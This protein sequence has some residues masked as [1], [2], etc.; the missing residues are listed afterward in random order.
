MDLATTPGMPPPDGQESH[1]HEPYNSLQTGTVLAFGITYLIATIFL[2]LRY[3][4]AFKLTKKIE[5]DLITITISYGIALVYFVTVVNLMN[6]GWGKHMWNVSLEELMEFNQVRLLDI[7]WSTVADKKQRL[8]V[9]TL[10]YLIC[11][12]ITKMAILSVLF[13]INPAK[14][15]R[16][17]VVALAVAIFAYTL[18]LCIITGGPCNPLHA[19]TTTCLKN[20]ALS[21]AVL[22]IASDLAVIA[23]PIPTIHSLHFSAKQKAMV[24]CLLA[25]GSGVIICSIARLPYVLLLSKTADTTYTEAILG[26]WSLVEVN[27]GI[28]CACAMRFKRLIAIYLPRLSLFS[29]RSH[30]TT[31]PRE[32]TPINKFQPKNSG[33]QHSY[34]LYSTQDGH[35][36]PF[37]G[38][39]DISVH[40]SFKT[41]EERTHVYSRDNDS[42]DKI[43]A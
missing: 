41:D 31:K 26:V 7:F 20:V 34:E 39:K 15:Y 43:L 29:S 35:A 38:T 19:G 16:Y 1:F 28:I 14:I 36:D 32:D 23:I 11:P 40:R 27:L 21:Q 17:L 3:F 13:Q 42:A 4:Q 30:G 2:G 10:T 5:V 37:A 25:L 12:S 9:N 8:L 33:G 22:N 18:T 24:G 6:Y